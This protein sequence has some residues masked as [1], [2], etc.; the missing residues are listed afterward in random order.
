MKRSAKFIVTAA[1]ATCLIGGS[2]GA[3]H[4]AN[5]VQVPAGFTITGSG[6][7]HGVGMS[8][9]GA[10]GMGLDG[11]TASQILT[12][13]YTGTTVDAVTLTSPNIRVGILQDRKFVAIRGE[14]VP[15]TASG[16]AFNIVVDANTPITVAPGA[17]ATFTTLNGLTEV[18][19]SGTV[20][21]G[22]TVTLNWVNADTVM[23]VRSGV[24][25]AS[26]VAALGTAVCVPIACTNRYRYGTLEIASGTYDDAVADLVVVN[27]LRLSDEYL[28][29]LGEVPSSWT[30]A[31]MQAQAIAGRSY[32]VNKTS[33]RSGCA[34]QIFATTLDQAFVGYSKEIATSGSR[35]V[36]AVNATIVNPSVDPNTAYVVRYNAKIIS[37]YYSSSTGGKSQ[38]TS[39]VWGSA[40]PYLVSVADPWSKD[41]RVNNSNAAWTDTVDQ[42]TLVANLRAQGIEIADVWSMTVTGNYPSG[43]ISKLS[44]SDSAGNI[45]TLTIAPTQKITPDELRGVLGTK[46][47]YISAIEPGI[48]TVAGSTSATAKKLTSLTKVNWPTSPVKPTDYNFTGRVSPAQVGATVKLQKRVG[49]KWKTVS[50]AT[51]NIKGSWAIL[52]TGPPAGNH[53]LRITATNSKGTIKTSTKQI[54]MAGSITTSAPKS[55][56]RKTSFTVSGSVN[57]GYAGVE[58]LVERKVGNGSW[59]RIAKVATDAEGKWAITRST[60]SSKMT[61]SYR[62]KTS[63]SRLGVIVSKTKKTVVR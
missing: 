21:L 49:G 36:A 25:A 30:E 22:T 60:G 51:T 11:Y 32:A 5:A 39:E 61:V 19:A 24:D 55:V 41:P 26:A 8:Q 56:K 4:S 12:H 42:V 17:V 34:C 2:V 57:P 62:A 1:L 58:V 38:P 33:T 23:F 47:T 35:W 7:G 28:Y 14:V 44:L 27:T 63:D 37:T 6:F 10:Q 9:Y 18:S 50:T 52:W 3:A 29:G 46:S 45:T 40:F 16:G 48:K 43:G 54:K 31:A 13:Y 15:G 20:L 59:K 53:D